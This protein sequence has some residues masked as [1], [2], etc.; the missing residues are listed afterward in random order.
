MYSAGL[1]NLRTVFEG[2][3]KMSESIFPKEEY[4]HSQY[5]DGKM[6]PNGIYKFGGLTKRELFAAMAMQGI[7][8]NPELVRVYTE[9]I[10]IMRSAVNEA[11]ALI[12]ELDKERE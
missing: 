10:Q 1:K 3:P 2:E 11:D 7:L 8:A 6:W 12:A 4:E 9:E 5:S